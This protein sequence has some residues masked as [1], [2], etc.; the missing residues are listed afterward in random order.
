MHGLSHALRALEPE[1]FHQLTSHMKDIYYAEE[2]REWNEDM[3]QLE[4]A[5]TKDAVHREFPGSEVEEKFNKFSENIYSEM[6]RLTHTVNEFS[7]IGHGDCWPPNFMYTYEG[8]SPVSMKIIDFQ[9]ARLGSCALDISFFIYSCTS[10]ELRRDHFDDM[11]MWY[12]EGVQ[13]TLRQ[14]PLDGEAVFPVSAL[15]EEMRQFARFGV[16]TAMEAIPVSIMS[17]SDTTDMDTIE[18]SH[19]LPLSEIWRLKPIEDNAGRRRLAEVV[20]H[21]VEQGYL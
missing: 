13:E 9:L 6:V 8:R 16:G 3:V 4:V 14:F 18:G 1:I 5:V 2:T 7:V 15:Q 19:P 10:D 11:L 21:A 12:Y 17:E 20:R